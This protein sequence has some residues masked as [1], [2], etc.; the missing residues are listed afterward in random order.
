MVHF[1]PKEVDSITIIFDTYTAM[2]EQDG[3]SRQWLVRISQRFYSNHS[4]HLGVC[5]VVDSAVWGP[6]VN[7]KMGPFCSGQ[8]SLA[9][10]KK[11]GFQELTP[12][13]PSPYQSRLKKNVP[14]SFARSPSL[15][16]QPFFL[17]FFDLF[18]RFFSLFH[19]EKKWYSAS[20]FSG[21]KRGSYTN[22]NTC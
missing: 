9:T 15:S 13:S 12:G 11:Y 2:L 4:L 14:K 7:N 21:G 3:V 5:S 10:E 1:Q 16:F 6:R 17:S 8:E 18:W 19:Q 22:L 20:F